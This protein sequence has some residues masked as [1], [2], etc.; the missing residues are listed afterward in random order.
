MT[1]R[2][3]PVVEL[4]GEQLRLRRSGV[5][6]LRGI[7]IDLHHLSDTVMTLAAIAPLCVGPTTI[8]NI[9]NIRI[10]ETDR[11]LATVTELRRLGQDVSH[12]DDWLR[13]VPKPLVP[14]AIECYGDHRIAM[15]F[16]VLGAIVDGITIT[17]PGCSAKTYPGFWDDLDSFR[18]QQMTQLLAQS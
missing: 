4:V 2:E 11:L 13:I 5:Q 12:G 3:R 16:A 8:R 6:I 15:S 17:D 18:H 7:D 10:K 9:A 1:G 14:A